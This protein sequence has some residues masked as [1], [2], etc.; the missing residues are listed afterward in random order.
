MQFIMQVFPAPL[1]PM[2]EKIS[3]FLTSKLTLVRAAT[4]WNDR[5]TF[6]AS[7]MTSDIQH[8]LCVVRH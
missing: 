4:P 1:G 8:P 3:P 7:S 6:F 2:M 5:K